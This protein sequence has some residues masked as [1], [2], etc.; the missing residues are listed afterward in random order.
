MYCRSMATCAGKT[1]L[2][3][4]CWWPTRIQWSPHNGG[5]NMFFAIN[6]LFLQFWASLLQV[7]KS[8][9]SSRNF[10]TS[11]TNLLVSLKQS[12]KCWQKLNHVAERR[13]HLV[14]VC[15][16]RQCSECSR[17]SRYGYTNMDYTS[18]GNNP[19]WCQHLDSARCTA[20]W[21]HTLIKIL[22]GTN[23]TLF[24]ISTRD[25]HQGN[26]ISSK[27]IWGW[28]KPPRPP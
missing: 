12:C 23:M 19:T 15:S 5:S 4:R 9:M 22:T 11:K 26:W 3:K 18:S 16:N 28:T 25:H 6:V 13:H 2:G 20:R 21:L 7:F 24:D 1:A 10:Y 27:T 14:F 17:L 8:F